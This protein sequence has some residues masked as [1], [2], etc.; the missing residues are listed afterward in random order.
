MALKRKTP[1][2]NNLE[3][4]REWERR[5]QDRALARV[6][7]RRPRKKRPSGNRKPKEK[8]APVVTA[9]RLWVRHQL[10]CAVPGCRSPRYPD[11]H[12]VRAKGMGGRRDEEAFDRENVAPLC[13]HHHQLGDSPGW[14][15]KRFQKELG[16]QL[17]EV[18]VRTWDQWMD[19]PPEERAFW[20]GVAEDVNEGRRKVA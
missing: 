8:R 13:R 4:Q 12:H 9:F 19:L 20:E 3:T 10:R 6:Q 11:P 2:K 17:Q 7:N 5:S 15:W 18:A 16:I 14:S 1:L